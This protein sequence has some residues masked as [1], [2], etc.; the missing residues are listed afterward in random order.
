VKGSPQVTC[1]AA[2]LS[3]QKHGINSFSSNRYFCNNLLRQSAVVPSI[4]WSM[5]N[6]MRHVVKLKAQGSK[7]TPHGGNYP[8][9]GQLFGS[10]VVFSNPFAP[11]IHIDLLNRMHVC[12]PLLESTKVVAADQ[13]KRRLMAFQQRTRD[14]VDGMVQYISSHNENYKYFLT[15]SKENANI[16]MEQGFISSSARDEILSGLERIEKDIG[17]GKFKWKNNVDVRTNI[18]EA[19]I[20]ITGAPAKRLDATISHYVQQLTV[21]QIWCCDSIDKIITQIKEL[22]VCFLVAFF[23]A[24]CHVVSLKS[25]GRNLWYLCFSD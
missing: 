4:A 10:D 13:R 24:L 18:I 15:A 6:D 17:D 5:D 1:V 3:G 14:F 8:Y 20:E 21:L 16:I 23:R 11:G 12:S 2:L 22:Q 25:I 19:L 7:R 9:D